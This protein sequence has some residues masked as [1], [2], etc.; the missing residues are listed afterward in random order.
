MTMQDRAERT[1]RNLVRAAAEEFCRNGYE[2]TSLTRICRLADAS[3]GALTFHFSTKSVLADAVQAAGEEAARALVAEVSGA[4]LPPLF[5]VREV[6]V[7]LARL[8]D[9]NAAVRSAARLTRERH[10][11]GRAWTDSWLPAVRELLVRA[12]KEDELHPGAPPALV[13]DLVEHLVAGAEGQHGGAA[14]MAGIWRL[15]LHG[16]A[17]T[18]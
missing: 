16:L 9:E 14:R 10:A 17:A 7:G 11:P 12:E 6:A 2:G 1:R 15:V 8:L 5:S 3:L 13:A 18:R 4:R